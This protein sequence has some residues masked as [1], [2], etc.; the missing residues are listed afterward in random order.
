MDLQQLGIGGNNSW[1]LLP[2]DKYKLFLNRPYYYEYR[3]VPVKK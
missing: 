2:L 3:I 1:G